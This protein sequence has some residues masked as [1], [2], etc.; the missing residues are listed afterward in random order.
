MCDT[1]ATTTNGAMEIKISTA[2]TS[3]RDSDSGIV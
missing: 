2:D 3:T 1:K